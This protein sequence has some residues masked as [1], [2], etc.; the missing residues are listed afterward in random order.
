MRNNKENIRRYFFMGNFLKMCFQINMCVKMKIILFIYSF[1]HLFIH[2]ICS[3]LVSGQQNLYTHTFKSNPHLHDW[4]KNISFF[5]S[6]PTSTI[7]EKQ[8]VCHWRRLISSRPRQPQLD[9]NYNKTKQ[10]WQSKKQTNKTN[11]SN[12]ELLI[13]Q[14]AHDSVNSHCLPM[15]LKLLL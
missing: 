6:E 2:L 5:F 8:M 12:E 3:F 4:K 7:L 13:S 11:T 9:C 10:N 15:C 14:T 1:V